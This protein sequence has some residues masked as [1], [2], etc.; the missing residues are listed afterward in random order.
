MKVMLI[1][2]PTADKASAAID[3]KVGQLS[4]PEELPGLAHFCEHLLFMGTEKYPKEN[5]YN[6]YL[7]SHAGNSNAYT[8]Q[9]DTNYFFEVN[10]DYLEGAL[11][12]FA[13]FFIC[14]LF[15]ENT[16][17][18]EIRAVDSEH[19]KNLQDDNWRIFQLE[20]SLTNPE[21]PF[22]K[23]GTGNIDT[24]QTIP[25]KRGIN[26]RE[27]LLKFHS[28]HYSANLMRLVVLGR[29]SLDQL[30]NWVVQKFSSVPN[31][32]LPPPHHRG[33]PLTQKELGIQYFVKPI[34]DM[35]TIELTFPIPDQQK[36]FMTK[37]GRYLSHLIGHEGSGSLLAYLKSRQLVNGLSSGNFHISQGVEFFQIS[38]DATEEG[39]Q[40]YEEIVEAV[41]AYIKVLKEANPQDDTY[42]KELQMLDEAEFRFQ[43]KTSP[44]AFAHS[45][46]SS[47]QIDYPPKWALSGSQLLREFNSSLIADCLD[48]LRP[49]NFRLAVVSKTLPVEF[50]S[51][52]KYYGTEYHVEPLSDRLKA[53]IENPSIPSDMRLPVP[54]IFIPETLN[55]EKYEI[56]VPAKRP[57]LIK[58]DE[59]TRLWYKR[60]DKFWVPRANV[61]FNIRCPA[62]GKTAA[63]MNKAMLYTELVKDALNEYAYDAAVAGL[64]YNIKNTEEGLEL[65]FEGFNDKMHV[66]VD[67]VAEK[68]R[69][70]KVDPLRFAVLKE[71]S[72]RKMKNWAFKAPYM[73][74][75]YHLTYLTKEIGFT[76]DELLV[77]LEE[78]GR[79]EVE[80]YIPK[81]LSQMHIE[82][83]VHGNV[84]KK[85]AEKLFTIVQGYLQ[86][87]PAPLEYR[88]RA[89][90]LPVDTKITAALPVVNENDVNSA[91][92][93]YYDVEP[94]SNDMARATLDLFGQVVKEA[95]FDQLRT[96]E[97]LGY[98]VSSGVRQ[99]DRTGFYIIIQSERKPEYLEKRIEHFTD[100][101]KTMLDDLTEVEFETHVKSVVDKKLQRLKNLGQESGRYWHHITTGSYNFSRVETDASNLQKVTKRNLID[102][103]EKYIN[104]VS[105]K[106]SS[107]SIQM[108]SQVSKIPE[109]VA[110]K[111]KDMLKTFISSQGLQVSEEKLVELSSTLESRNVDVVIDNVKSGLHLDDSNID[112]IEKLVREGFNLMDDS[113]TDDVEKSDT[114]KK[115]GLHSTSEM[116]EYKLSLGMEPPLSPIAPIES[117]MVNTVDARL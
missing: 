51:V 54:N 11:D 97:Q 28:D 68:M 60:D 109:A 93:H 23:F 43:E 55:V 83:L 34:N 88:N 87:K 110:E 78:V 103:Y 72:V 61:Y 30:E 49:D 53:L 104:R 32:S 112:E 63:D 62:A 36:E 69:D 115:V 80:E 42:W 25:V 13:Q 117:F 71:E 44:S 91:I 4:D 17:D 46:A 76:P 31:K 12:R 8:S 85:E 108:D 29:D 58:Y 10:Y 5:D 100:L 14:P 35:Q 79:I 52:E 56:A 116:A 89:L 41:F 92:I 47:L 65:H 84:S 81:L 77:S 27:R 7:N 40:K 16:T 74:G 37:A 105:P 98:I 48:H 86:N 19:K 95:T 64:R 22:Q 66:L 94:V 90:I 70:V 75:L 1:S 9:D 57:T 2:D 18:R 96:K 59:G 26:I 38:I 39:I 113:S 107:L 15:L 102:F 50:D 21:Y 33:H 67:K 82:G 24:L 114:A 99:T 101:L 106:I 73:Q 3:V 20:K 45:L 111:F 6:E